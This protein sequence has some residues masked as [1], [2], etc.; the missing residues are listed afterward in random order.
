[1]STLP[2]LGGWSAG[3]RQ[4]EPVWKLEV[5]MC[6]SD[7]YYVVGCSAELVGPRAL[8]KSTDLTSVA[9]RSDG[10]GGA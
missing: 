1:M 2:E 9:G 6:G 7:V 3:C 10:A 4:L 8:S 5:A